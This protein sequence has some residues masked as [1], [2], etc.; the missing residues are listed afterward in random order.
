MQLAPV[1]AQVAE[2][3]SPWEIDPFS[4]PVEQSLDLLRQIDR[5]L[6]SVEGVTLAEAALNFRRYEQWFY[7]SEGSDIHQTRVVT[8]AGYTAYAFAGTEIM[9]RSYPN[10]FGGQY[11]NR[12]YELVH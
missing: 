5:E 7:S 1:I 4:I 8:G 10:S 6:R 2:G 12:G 3:S 9:K 11:Q